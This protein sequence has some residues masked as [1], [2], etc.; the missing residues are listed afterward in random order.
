VVQLGPDVVADKTPLPFFGYS[1]PHGTASD[2]RSLM[3]RYGTPFHATTANIDQNLVDLGTVEST[4]GGSRRSVACSPLTGPVN[5]RPTSIGEDILGIPTPGR[6]STGA[7]RYALWAKVRVTIEV[8][9]FGD[10]WVHLSTVPAGRI[11][12]LTLPV[13]ASAKPWSVRADGACFI[14]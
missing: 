7:L 3:T 6:P 10:H 13:L 14:T 9:R 5:L 2:M 8:R 11:F 12:R 4:L 1:N